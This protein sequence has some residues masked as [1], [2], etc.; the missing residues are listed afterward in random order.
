MMKERSVRDV[1]RLLR[2]GSMIVP[3]V[4]RDF[5]L[6]AD[7]KDMLGRWTWQ[8]FTIE[9]RE[10]ADRKICANIVGGPKNVG[11]EIFAS[12]LTNKEGAWFGDVVNPETGA[13]YRTRMQFTGSGTWH[14]DGCTASRVCLSGEFVRSH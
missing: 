3:L 9:I 14:L 7:I 13:T 10:C 4:F 6:A 5:A 2:I 12:E 11:L 1:R 8:R